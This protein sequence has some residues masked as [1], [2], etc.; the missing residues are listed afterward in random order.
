MANAAAKNYLNNLFRLFIFLL[1]LYPL[2]QLTTIPLPINDVHLYLQDLVIIL[3]GISVIYGFIVFKFKLSQLPLLKP[4]FLFIA[5]AGLSLFVNFS[6]LSLNQALISSLYLCRWIGYSAIFFGCVILFKYHPDAHKKLEK[7]LIWA[8]LA[9]ALF[10]LLQ[11]FFYPSLRNLYYL[12]WDPH[13]FRIFGTFLDPGFL[14]LIFVLSL[15]ML[16]LKIIEKR[17]KFYLISALIVFIALA[18]TYSRS[19]YL[20]LGISLVYLTYIYKKWSLFIGLIFIGAVAFFLL[21]RNLPSVGVNLGRTTSIE[22]RIGSWSESVNLI[23]KSPIFGLGFDTL[24]YTGNQLP[25]QYFQ[26]NPITSHSATG[27]ENSLLFVLTTTGIVG[28]FSYLYLLYMIF[29]LGNVLVKVSL[30]SILVHSF[31]NNSLFYPWVM[32]W[33]WIIIGLNMTLDKL[34]KPSYAKN[35]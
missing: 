10:G 1:V 29:K 17:S 20:A 2:G 21:P 34:K 15:I 28:F 33:L 31:F 30:I 7:G 24:R 27:V 13:D 16:Y 5:A 22:G 19:S 32:I 12:G 35:I 3:I 11:Y 6:Q 9:T 18:L 26:G 8:G 4:I 23:S 14:G 25:S